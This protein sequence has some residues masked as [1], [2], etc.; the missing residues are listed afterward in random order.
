MKN[1]LLLLFI[2]LI[3]TTTYAQK[4]NGKYFNSVDQTLMIF[5]QNEQDFDFQVSWGVND[6]WGCFFTASGTAKFTSGTEA[7]YG[8]DAEW[9]DIQ[10]FFGEGFD[11]HVEAGLDF[12]GNDCARFGDSGSE[13][14]TFFKK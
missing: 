8:I 3:T 2:T 6:E 1:I 7:Y 10:F 12:M 5:N 14:Y 9:P 4:Y 11:L 13:K